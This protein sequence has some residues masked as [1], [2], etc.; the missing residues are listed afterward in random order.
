MVRIDSNK[1]LWQDKE[2]FELYTQAANA[3]VNVT[4]QKPV[5]VALLTQVADG[6]DELFQTYEDRHGSMQDPLFLW[7]FATVNAILYNE[8][9]E[10]DASA[11]SEKSMRKQY[12]VN[13]YKEG[14]GKHTRNPSYT[15]VMIDGAMSMMSSITAENDGWLRENKS[16]FVPV[17]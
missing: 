17:G 1:H 10:D 13:A 12:A 8:S 2:A 3:I 14:L 5:N 6:L 15:Q 4:N 16:R 11:F 7:W 9:D